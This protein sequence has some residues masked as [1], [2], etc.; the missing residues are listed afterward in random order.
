MAESRQRVPPSL[1]RRDSRAVASA[2]A[3]RAQAVASARAARA[4]VM[5]I[6]ISRVLELETS[7]R[8]FLSCGINR[9]AAP[10]PLCHI[11]R[12]P[13]LCGRSHL[14][15]ATRRMTSPLLAVW[16]VQFLNVGAKIYRRLTLKRRDQRIAGFSSTVTI[17]IHPRPPL[18]FRGK[19]F[20]ALVL[21]PVVPM[22]DWLEDLDA[23]TRNS[24]GFFSG[25][26]VILDVSLRSSL[27]SLSSNFFLPRCECGTSALRAWKA[28]PP[29]SLMRICP[30]R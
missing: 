11:L 27:R 17:V 26:P 21:S 15:V 2:R 25:R 1:P 14:L 23:L 10:P 29:R 4:R 9:N 18:R 7:P 13:S 12:T 30:R 5:L 24:P 19:S 20:L 22:R 3:A 28:Q 8:L 16:I 6:L